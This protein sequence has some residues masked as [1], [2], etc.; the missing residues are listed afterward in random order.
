MKEKR[1]DLCEFRIIIRL[2]QVPQVLVSSNTHFFFSTTGGRQKTKAQRFGTG[3]VAISSFQGSTTWLALTHN[4]APIWNFR[5]IWFS[6]I[7]WLTT[8]T[9]SMFH[10]VSMCFLKLSLLLSTYRG[11]GQLFS[12]SSG[13][14]GRNS[15]AL[16]CTRSRPS[17]IL[18]DTEDE[19]GEKE[20]NKGCL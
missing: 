11:D 6:I 5:F 3:G 20:L 10:A 16:T 17:S 1:N 4:A 7:F 15:H 14:G 2:L 12:V 19:W 8:L 13:G 18:I 9:R